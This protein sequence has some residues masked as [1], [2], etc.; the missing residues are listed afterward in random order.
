MQKLALRAR[1]S[2]PHLEPRGFVEERRESALGLAREQPSD[3]GAEELA[4]RAMA[5]DE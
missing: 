5:V 4:R 2:S 1:L 3:N